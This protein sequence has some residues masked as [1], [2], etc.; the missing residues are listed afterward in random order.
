MSYHKILVVKEQP[1]IFASKSQTRQRLQHN[2]EIT[3]I[4]LTKPQ[5]QHACTVL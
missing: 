2:K 3:Q 4:S 5:L 1:L